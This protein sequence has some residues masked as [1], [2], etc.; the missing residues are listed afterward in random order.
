MAFPV[1]GKTTGLGLSEKSY[2]ELQNSLEPIILQLEKVKS[3]SD[4][5]MFTQSRATT[6]KLSK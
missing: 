4:F 2:L 1:N 5:I 6:G 3:I